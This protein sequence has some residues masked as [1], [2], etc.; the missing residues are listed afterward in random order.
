MPTP[1]R[2]P[3]CADQPPP[4]AGRERGERADRTEPGAAAEGDLADHERGADQDDAGEIDDH[5]RGPAALADLGR[6]PPDV[7]QPDGRA[8][9]RQN[10][11][12]AGAPHAA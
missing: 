4:A 7:A 12:G 10:E 1:R 6:E 8:G 5:E 3:E 9:R 11:A 2:H